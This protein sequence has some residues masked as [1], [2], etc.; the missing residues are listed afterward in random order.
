MLQQQIHLSFREGSSDKVYQVTLEEKE[1]GFLVN[2]AFGRR[3]A[4]LN[5][6]SK[7]SSPVDLPSAQKIFDKLVK[8]KKGKG[9]TEDESGKPNYSNSDKEDTGIRCQLL[10]PIEE[11]EVNAFLNDDNYIAQQKEDGNRM[12]VVKRQQKLI[13]VNRKGQSIGF[14]DTLKPLLEIKG[15]FALDGESINDK[16]HVFD[17]LELNGEDLRLLPFEKRF[18]ILVDFVNKNDG[19]DCLV[20]V[21]T[22][23]GREQKKALYDNLLKVN[24]EGIVFKDRRSKY[25]P[26]RPASG[27]TQ[28]KF[29]FCET[30]SFVVDSVNLK[31]SVMLSLVD[32]NGKL[33]EAGNVTIPPNYSVPEKGDIVE[34]KYLYA[35]PES[36]S[37]YQPVYL[38]KRTDVEKEEC[39]T[40]QLKYKKPL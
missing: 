6:G 40:S 22:A 8:E 2:F 10:N 20:L 14:S 5:T 7:T 24:A 19:H 27:G 30:A 12:G 37:I 9:Y 23:I 21:E 31:R 29:K 36:G 16:L 34:V 38:G 26:G 11:E 17:I 4:A 1:N 35:F 3:G 32:A 18:E 39:S 13:V 25:T 15:D 28:R 33:A